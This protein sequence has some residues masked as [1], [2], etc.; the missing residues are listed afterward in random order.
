MKQAINKKQWDVC[1]YKLKHY[2]K[3]QRKKNN[4]R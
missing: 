4:I 2:E 1:K 3:I